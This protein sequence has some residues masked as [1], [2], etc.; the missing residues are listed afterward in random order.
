M[1]P[2]IGVQSSPKVAQSYTVPAAVGGWNA[3]DSLA[4]MEPTDAVYLSNYFPAPTYVQIRLGSNNYATNLPGQ[5]E[6][7]LDYEGGAQSTLF[8]VSNGKIFNITAGGGVP[9]ASV[10]GLANSRLQ[11]VNVATT[12]GEFLLAVNGVNKLQG[13]DG[14]NWYVDGDGSHDITGLDTST[15]VQINLFKNRVWFV[16][17]NSLNVYY[18]N[19]LAIAGAATIFPLQGV[20]RLGGYVVACGTWT[21]DGGYGLDDNLVFITSKGEIIVYQGTDPTSVTTFALMGVWQLGA[22]VGRRCFLKYGGDLLLVT[23]D[24]L[25]PM[26]AALQSSRL[27][28]R[29]SLTNKIQY[30]VSSAVTEFGSN[31]GW[32]VIYFPKGNMLL[33]NIPTQTGSGQVQYVM[34][35]ITQAWCDFSNWNANCWVL[36]Q[37]KIYF[38]GA[39]VVTQ[40]W[41]GSADNGANI[42]SDAKQAFNPLGNPGLLKRCTMLKPII[43]TS[44]GT[45]GLQ[46]AINVDFSD[47]NPYTN[48]SLSPTPSPGGVW[49]VMQWG[50]GIWGA[51][52]SVQNLWQGITGEGYYVAIRLKAVSNFLTAQWMASTVV[53]EQGGIL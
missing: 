24:G 16:Q 44:G 40:A 43:A 4:N 50:T 34:N 35:T 2:R 19:P 8:A 27:D 17:N 22:P 10:S 7:L 14:T 1:A 11:Y 18:L 12:G 3:R 15:C 36:W 39:G 23:Q 49:G 32:E 47:A 52:V 25:L 13:F 48:A 5:V 51:G 30:A 46:A 28:P 20:A 6:S 42:T 9:A 26:S 53:Y 38:G 31:F 21:V 45:P 37:D 33:L 41:T 29:V